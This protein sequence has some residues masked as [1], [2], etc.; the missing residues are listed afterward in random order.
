MARFYNGH[1]LVELEEICQYC[2]REQ[3]EGLD[4]LYGD[5]S[6]SPRIVLALIAR[7]RELGGTD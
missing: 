3:T 4:S 6:E 7:V 5:E 1:T 2:E